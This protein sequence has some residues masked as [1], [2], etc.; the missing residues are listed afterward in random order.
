M[1]ISFA[2]RVH[3]RRRI[4]AEGQADEIRVGGVTQEQREEHGVAFF[5]KQWGGWGADGKK[6]SKKDNGRVLAGKIWDQMPA[7]I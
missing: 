2:G 6:R 5:F 1:K 7:S 4:R 3:R